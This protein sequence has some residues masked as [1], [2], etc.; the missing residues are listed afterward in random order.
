MIANLG[1]SSSRWTFLH[2]AAAAA[3]ALAACGGEQPAP[4]TPND[5]LQSAIPMTPST[6]TATPLSAPE[7][8][9]SGSASAAPAASAAPSA[10][11]KSSGSGRPPVLKSNEKS[12]TDTFGSSP[13]KLEIGDD[14]GRAT[15]RIPEGAL[16]KGY[17]VTFQLDPK[18]KSG[19]AQVGQLYRIRTQVAGA[20]D[21]S[22][23]DSTGTPFQLAMPA[24]G[25]KDANLAIGETTT[26]DKGREKIKWTVVAPTRIDD[27]T[28]TAFFDLPSLGADT[29]LH[30][31]T[32]A[33]SAPAEKK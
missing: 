32:K 16:E 15:L 11:P 23:V 1:S 9:A 19:G 7:P 20:Q 8:A 21:F 10:A 2:A 28:N 33:P 12:I 22:K 17:N 14:K 13:A 4:A 26:D 18:A 3:L 27:A 5:P 6:V 24:G 29:V 25:K 30:V 31:T